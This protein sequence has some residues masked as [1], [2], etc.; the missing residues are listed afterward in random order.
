MKIDNYLKQDDNSFFTKKA[1]IR[2]LNYCCSKVIPFMQADFIYY[3]LLEGSNMGLRIIK[4]VS[5]YSGDMNKCKNS[6]YI[7][8]TVK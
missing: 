7:Q 8:E 2:M 6:N 4:F 1:E 5:A 3:H